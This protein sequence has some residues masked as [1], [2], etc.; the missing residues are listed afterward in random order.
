MLQIVVNKRNA[1]V[2]ASEVIT[3]G[4]AGQ[5]CGFSFSEDWDGLGRMAVFRGS[6]ATVEMALF[7]PDYRCAI[8]SETVTEPGGKLLVG[9]YGT[10]GTGAAAIPTVWVVPGIVQ[11]GAGSEP[12]Q[13]TASLV[14]QILAA[15]NSAMDTSN[16]AMEIAYTAQDSAAASATA[17]AISAEAAASSEDAA[18]GSAADAEKA[19]NAAALSAA[20]AGNSAAAASDSASQAAGSAAGASISAGNAAASVTAAASSASAA[21]ASAED[22]AASRSDAMSAR[23]SAAASAR[24]AESWAVGETGTR[25]GENTNNAAFFAELAGQRA[26]QAGFAW[27]DVNDEDGKLYVTVT[28][29][30]KDAVTFAVNEP[31]GILEVTIT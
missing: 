11:P 6:G 24:L 20:G 3:T 12:T 31:V 10:D 8:P 13:P 1:Y 26:A 4:S 18:A 16:E 23:D 17:A 7:G 27:F 28:D 21:A 5:V 9:V 15:A 30:I 14:D 29:N 2:S 22:A 19:A 25:S